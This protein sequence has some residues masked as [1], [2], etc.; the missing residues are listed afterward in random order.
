MQAGFR[1]SYAIAATFGFQIDSNTTLPSPTLRASGYHC[2][3]VEQ[4][5]PFPLHGHRKGSVGW[6]DILVPCVP[7]K[8]WPFRQRARAMSLRESAKDRGTETV[9]RVRSRRQDRRH[10]WHGKTLVE[11]PQLMPNDQNCPHRAAGMATGRVVERQTWNGG[12]GRENGI[13]MGPEPDR[14]GQ[15]DARR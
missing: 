6:C 7:E 11:G 12:L 8:Y 13:G 1:V 5:R 2:G 3:V 15:E 10:G 4:L 14:S 9:G